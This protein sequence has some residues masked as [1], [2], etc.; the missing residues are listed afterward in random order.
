VIQTPERAKYFGA[1]AERELHRAGLW[2]DARAFVAGGTWSAAALLHAAQLSLPLLGA[3]VRACGRGPTSRQ[4]AGCDRVIA[5][6]AEVLHEAEC[7]PARRDVERRLAAAGDG[8]PLWLIPTAWWQGAAA[9]DTWVDAAGR[10]QPWLS[11]LQCQ[12]R[13]RLLGPLLCRPTESDFSADVLGEL[14]TAGVERL[15]VGSDLALQRRAAAAGMST[16]LAQPVVSATE[17]CHGLID[18]RPLVDD[19]A[20]WIAWQP[21]VDRPL[22]DAT[23]DDD[24]PAGRDVLRAVALA[25]LALPE[26]VAVRMPLAAVEPKTAGV[27]LEFGAAHLGWLA[28]DAA[29]AE[30][31]HLPQVADLADLFEDTPETAPQ[32]VEETI[33]RGAGR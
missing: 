5:C 30:A 24:A 8:G 28:A 29:T 2:D 18:L 20:T 15:F 9:P 27:A 1:L 21:Q 32:P 3:L 13:V 4:E 10:L 14:R 19:P 31:L 11:G 25:R 33:H 23:L 6:P 7:G 26:R 16:I 17:L 22:G 12:H